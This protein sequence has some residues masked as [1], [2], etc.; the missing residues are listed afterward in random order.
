M[1]IKAVVDEFVEVVKKD[2]VTILICS[3]IGIVV[4]GISLGILGYVAMT[5]VGLVFLKL[6]RDEKPDYK[7]VFA[8]I[9]KFLYLFLLALITGILTAIGLILLV[10]PGLIIITLFVYS[11]FYLA[12]EEK[13]IIESMKLSYKTV[14]N[15]NLLAHFLLVIIL[16][17]INFIVVSLGFIGTIITYPLFVGIIVLLF[18][19]IKQTA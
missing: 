18:E 8:Y 3:L 6:K 12:Y 16:L 4:T 2:A 1:E 17:A 5:G 11:P 9:N 14:I 19:K 13:G 7:D 15:N 10:I